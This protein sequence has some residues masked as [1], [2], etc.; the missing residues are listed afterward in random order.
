MD[1]TLNNWVYPARSK[2]I[3]SLENMQ[4]IPSNQVL[5]QFRGGGEGGHSSAL[6]TDQRWG[7]WIPKGMNLS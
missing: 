1:C 5:S 3:P 7:V 4:M 2:E 6:L